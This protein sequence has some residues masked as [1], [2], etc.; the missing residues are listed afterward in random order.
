[1]L[2]LRTPSPAPP[3]IR[4]YTLPKTTFGGVTKKVMKEMLD[5]LG[6]NEV[7]IVFARGYQV[8]KIDKT[9]LC[10]Q[11]PFFHAAFTGNFREAEDRCIRLKHDYPGAI[12]AMMHFLVTGYYGLDADLVRQ[13][14]FLTMLDLHIHAYVVADKYRIPDLAE[15]AIN[16]YRKAVADILAQDFG[17]DMA[18][19]N[20]KPERSLVESPHFADWR[21]SAEVDRFLNSVVL[22]WKNTPDG[23][24]EMRYTVLELIKPCLAK[25]ARVRMFGALLAELEEFGMDLERSLYEDGLEV[26]VCG[27]GAK[28]RHLV[29]FGV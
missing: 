19:A 14:G 27:M 13:N 12:K 9:L 24:D 11:S 22:L 23:I 16:E 2:S 29:G 18:G 5:T 25:L 17:S 8:A 26:V 7:A 28:G 4:F 21:P 3:P 1:M 6:P 15:Y 20:A 10:R